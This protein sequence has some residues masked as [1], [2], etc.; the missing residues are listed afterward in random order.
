MRMSL[1]LGSFSSG[2]SG[3]RPV[4]SSRISET[5]SL[6]SCVLSAS[7]STSTYCDTSCCTCR[8]ISSSGTLS[9]A[10]RLISS[11]RRRC[12]RTLASRSL[13]LSNGLSAAGGGACSDGGSGNVHEALSGASGGPCSGAGTSGAGARRSVKRPTILASD[14]GKPELFHQ[15]NGRAIGRRFGN[16]RVEHQ[17]LELRRDLV[18]RLDLIEGHAAIDCFPHQRVVVGNRAQKGVAQCMGKIAPA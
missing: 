6:S 9:S 18:A 15:R 4:I 3:P 7:R 11:I 8:R 5:K 16:G 17:L 1:M 14:D 12:R 2:S 10:E 13:S